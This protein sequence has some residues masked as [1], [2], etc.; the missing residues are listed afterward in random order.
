MGQVIDLVAELRKDNRSARTIELEVFANALQTYLE[1]S[2]NVARNGAICAHPRT[3]TPIENPYLKIQTQAGAVLA[4]M[5][6][7]KSDRIV[8]LLKDQAPPAA[9]ALAAPPA[10]QPAAANSSSGSAAGLPLRT[11]TLERSAG[12][13]PSRPRKPSQRTSRVG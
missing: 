4:K 10:S 12:V 5:R 11:E 9:E 13:K 6:T 1:A 7:I 8:Q 3:G 2:E